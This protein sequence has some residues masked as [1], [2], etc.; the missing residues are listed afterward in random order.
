MEFIK[1]FKK[2]LG[3]SG[4]NSTQIDGSMPSNSIRIESN[5]FD[6]PT[7]EQIKEKL[8]RKANSAKLER[9]VFN[10]MFLV[11]KFISKIF[12]GAII[13]VVLAH[14]A[15]ELREQVPSLYRFV[16]IIMSAMEALFANFW[17]TIDKIL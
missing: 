13:L 14:F 6:T 17:Q 11:I 7:E 3:F 12:A 2:V 4:V 8:A 15:P 16:D 10:A 1:R 5:K 9:T